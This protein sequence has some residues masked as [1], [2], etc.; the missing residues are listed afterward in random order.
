MNKKRI[1][2]KKQAQSMI[3]REILYKDLLQEN[4]IYFQEIRI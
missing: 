4:Q 3:N 1:N 2:L